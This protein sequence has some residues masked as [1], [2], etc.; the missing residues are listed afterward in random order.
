MKIFSNK[1]K[2]IYNFIVKALS[3]FLAL[4]ICTVSLPV[5]SLADQ[6]EI[7]D[8]NDED[9]M[10]PYILQELE[11]YR[12][13]DTKQFLM[14]DNTIQAV[15]YNE[16]VH[17]KENG[18]WEDLDNSLEYQKS[19]ND[20]DF[21]GYKTKNGSFD[22]K[23]AKNA[24]SDKLVKISEGKY[25][26][27]WNLLNRSKIISGI[28]NIE[29]E[30][31]EINENP[32]LVEQRVEN[33][34]QSVLYKSIIHHTD[35]E[36]TVSGNGLK[37]NIIVNKPLD[38]Y[39][40]S[41]EIT[42]DNLKLSLQEDQSIIAADIET[43]KSIYTIPPMFMYDS[44][45]EACENINVSLKQENDTTYI[46]II[47]ANGDWINDT[48]RKFPIIIDPQIKSKQVDEAIEVSCISS[49]KILSNLA[50]DNN[51]ILGGY[52]IS[53][54]FT[55]LLLKFNLPKLESND[56]VVDAKLNLYETGITYSNSD[57]DDAQI[58]AY[59]IKSLWTNSTTWAVQPVYSLQA[60]DHEF[61]KKSD[62]IAIDKGNAVLKSWNITK[63]VKAWYEGE[64]KNN[65]IVL[66]DHNILTAG[67][68]IFGKFAIDSSKNTNAYPFLT[69]SYKNNKGLENYWTYTSVNSG[70]NDTAYI[71]DYSGNV[72]ASH[73][74]AQTSGNR[75]PVTIEHIYNSCNAE[76]LYANIYP[77]CG[78]GW[79]LNIQQ[80]IR[81]SKLYGLTGN[82]QKTYP[83]VYEDGDGTEHYFYAKTTNNTTKYYDEDG[84]GLEL[85][86]L[87]NGYQ[88][89]D[90]NKNI[91]SFNSSGNITGFKNNQ[92]VTSNITITY[93]NFELNG[94]TVASI[95]KITDG[96]G[97]IINLKNK[98]ITDSDGKEYLLL[99][100]I[101][102]ETGIVTLMS[103][104]SNNT[105]SSISN[106]ASGKTTYKYTTKYTL[107]ERIQNSKSN[108]SINFNYKT[109]LY[110]ERLLGVTEYQNSS[111]IY[112][113]NYDRHVLNETKIT[114]SLKGKS[115]VTYVQFDNA[116]RTIST[117]N[118][119]SDNYL[120]FASKNTYNASSVNS[121]GS[122]IKQINTLASTTSAKANT[123]N[124][125][126]NPSA[127]YDGIWK[128]SQAVGQCTFTNG[129]GTSIKYSGNRSFKV[130]STA[131][132]NDGRARLYQD[133]KSDILEAGKTYTLSAY[134]RTMNIKQASTKYDY[135]A[136]LIVT[137]NAGNS[138]SY[139]SNYI[140]EA[141]TSTAING[142][143]QRISVT[144]S[145]P[146]NMTSTRINLA[147]RN[148]TGTVY[149]DNVQLEEGESPSNFNLLEN[150]CMRYVDSSSSLPYKWLAVA[151]VNDRCD[152]ENKQLFFE[153]LGNAT[154]NKYIY[155]DVPIT[156]NESDTYTVS[157]WAQ[158]NASCSTNSDR[159]FDICIK[160]TYS[161]N[162]YIWKP[163]AK[164]NN[165]VGEWQY[166][167]Q[168]FDLSDG[169]SANKTPVS[170][171]ICARYKNQVNSVCFSNFQLIKNN[172]NLYTYDANGNLT[173]STSGYAN[174]STNTYSGNNITKSVDC[175]GYATNYS[176]DSYNNLK[177]AVSQ[178]EVSTNYTYDDYGNVTSAV[179]VNKAGTMKIATDIFYNNAD[180]ENGIN[181]GSY[182]TKV[183]DECN[184]TTKYDYD[185]VSGNLNSITDLSGN[186]TNFKYGSDGTIQQ[187]S[188]GQ[189]TNS[190]EYNNENLSSITRENSDNSL[191]TYNFD[192]NKYGDI[193]ETE[194]GSRTLYN[195][196][197]D[198]DSKT[199][200]ST[201]G[202][203]DTVSTKYS[204]SGLL[205]SQSSNDS[206]QYKW[207]YDNSGNVYKYSDE[208]NALYSNYDYDTMNRVSSKTTYLSNSNTPKSIT[209]FGYDLKGN[210]INVTNSAGGKIFSTKYTY[211]KDNL[212]T[213]TD[214]ATTKYY[215]YSYDTLNRINKKALHIT[216]DK[217]ININYTYALSGR[218]PVG[219]ETYR[220]KQLRQEIIDNTAYRYCYDK[221][222]NIVSIDQGIRSGTTTASDHV[223]MV[224]YKYDNLNQLTREDNKYLN[225]TIV[226][227]YDGVG[228]LTNK[229]IYP[230][231]DG[232][233]TDAL[234]QNIEYLYNDNEWKDLLTS[235]NGTNIK[236]D[237]IGNPT[238][239]LGNTLDWQ[240]RQL[241]SLSNDNSKVTYTYDSN[242][243][244]VSKTVNGVKTYYQ[245][246]GDKLL[247]QE[248][249]N[250]KLYFWY[251][252]FGNLCEIYFVNGSSA[253]AY[254]V[255]CN[256]RG[257]VEALYNTSGNLVAKYL[258]DSW[259]NTIS[260]TDADGKAIISQ[261]HIGNINPIR[262]RG[263]Y[264]DTETGYY[265]LQ[266]RY[267]NPIVGRFL[268]ADVYCD[269]GT[270]LLS[271][272]MFAYCGNN[273]IMYSDS[274]GFDFTWST[275]FDI[276]STCLI[277]DSLF[278]EFRYIPVVQRTKNK[279]IP[280]K[281]PR[282]KAGEHKKTGQRE[283]NVG[284]PNGEEHSVKPK[285][286]RVPNGNGSHR[287]SLKYDV[288][289]IF[290][291]VTLIIMVVILVLDDSTVI[292]IVDDTLIIPIIG[293]V[294]T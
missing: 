5:M 137:T 158:A 171:R 175:N 3:V 35:L 154:E 95:S 150:T 254:L 281:D 168:T 224:T 76:Q 212:V 51:C 166:A 9:E 18:E 40:F 16:P 135:G 227:T 234:L 142:G 232:E 12:T 204:N 136:V 65:G 226:Y 152:L 290:E 43:N 53:N 264:L 242:G 202:N 243:L 266:S 229:A 185:T 191:Q 197:I 222:G 282:K 183:V 11:E 58:N 228:N 192:Y 64:E 56:M 214:M 37:E 279:Y 221:N 128:A 292:G 4:V 276:I 72:V 196:S 218:N 67:G 186:I 93:S 217:I 50:S 79:K 24:N 216:D 103:Y 114:T 73:I 1:E 14:S 7:I 247:Y 100:S 205:L 235:Y 85:K 54:G 237:E 96:A 163:E 253:S 122:N 283:R 265:Y 148:A 181:A 75:S 78:L 238:S 165:A 55:R 118:E 269:T 231:T 32:T 87:S 178:R 291:L 83:Y 172:G 193:S 21:N 20:D 275:V 125:L 34:S 287:I 187:M 120:F 104:S 151:A 194:I 219:E 98:I 201:Y 285:G 112:G 42:A 255:T 293:L 26:L 267:Y 240:G 161:D 29:I 261:S 251:D 28:N 174:S 31:S 131:S 213:K 189:V 82:S 127:E 62:K 215:N 23:F 91:T 280:R 44:N 249:G 77:S 258:Y 111:K 259:G 153:M 294:L 130:V 223:R 27:S 57:M 134:V 245:Y 132:T 273:P 209:S 220:T 139:S 81:S 94:K 8:E 99:D 288:I 84:L 244:R 164:F 92:K 198:E 157:G 66:K 271:T 39:M 19:T 140:K 144:F 41:F 117:Y 129:Y 102:D 278:P 68:K 195:N 115:N 52:D 2:H 110:G 106:S 230:Y 143:W 248:T 126:K 252:A 284:H 6:S 33:A 260:I 188:N 46:L 116:G 182:V 25:N 48:S 63:A 241:V 274:D 184:T 107:L 167:L 169:T 89:V 176:Y 30:E 170:I 133:L 86:V 272:N 210:V 208:V 146:E 88:I 109:I 250:Q 47:D 101:T 207:Q 61:L 262:Y 59:M 149:Y 141:T 200:T 270:S 105:L 160:V 263:Y 211:T 36:Y 268:N 145:I 15:M 17:Y 236:Y 190:Y 71:N 156:G 119:Q 13:I 49:V 124:L 113:I 277:I 90:K 199:V 45:G 159:G 162:S 239:Y 203:G 69:I 22:V 121:S 80:T 180:I 246:S 123:E 108:K 155:Q 10:E 286:N 206:E 70:S 38:D 179:D 177:T 173:S 74:D 256:S 257:D 147:L 60:L 289:P 97:H 233:L 225:Q 138:K